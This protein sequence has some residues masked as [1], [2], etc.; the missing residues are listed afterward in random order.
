MS[1]MLWKSKVHFYLG[2]VSPGLTLSG[3][4]SI[5]YIRICVIALQHHRKTF[6]DN[7]RH[8]ILEG[9]SATESHAKTG[10]FYKG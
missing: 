6:S 4:S 7:S 10:Y 2:E 9:F 8:N 5:G 3:V 1:G